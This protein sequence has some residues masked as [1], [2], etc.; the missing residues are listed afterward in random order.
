MM[1]FINRTGIWQITVLS[2]HIDV[3]IGTYFEFFAITL[4]TIIQH[5]SELLAGCI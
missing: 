1:T 2:N 5:S 3:N 4:N